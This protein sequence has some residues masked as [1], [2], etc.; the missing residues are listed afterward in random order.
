M[1]VAICTVGRAVSGGWDYH[2][3]KKRRPMLL[4]QMA[5]ITGIWHER[6]RTWLGSS[7]FQARA[8]SYLA[9]PCDTNAEPIT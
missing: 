9:L 5:A 6:Y 2:Q 4:N 3:W 1:I 7:G 8:K